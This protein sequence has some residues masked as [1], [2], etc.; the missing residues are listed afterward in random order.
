MLNFLAMFRKQLF[1]TVDRLMTAEP[2]YIIMGMS[3]ETFFGGWEGNKDLKEELSVRTG[4]NIAT[5]AE[6]CKA[7]L[8]KFGAKRITVSSLSS[9][10]TDIAHVPEAWCEKV[11]RENLC[12]PGVE[13]WR[14]V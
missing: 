11:V 4:L 6:A 10:A 8:K 9:G 1:T 2:Q 7:S 13:S 3:L 5:G 12:V 14:G